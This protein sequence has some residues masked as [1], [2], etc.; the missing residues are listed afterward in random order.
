MKRRH[1]VRSYLLGDG[2][3]EVEAQCWFCNMMFTSQCRHSRL[4][5]IIGIVRD[6]LLR[7]EED[8][9]PGQEW[10]AP[11]IPLDSRRRSG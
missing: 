7:H 9:H 8:A 10:I 11:V 2:R 1:V 5:C 6:Q 3:C 4:H